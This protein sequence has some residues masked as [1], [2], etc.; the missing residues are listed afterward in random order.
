MVNTTRHTGVSVARDLEAFFDGLGRPDFVQEQ[1]LLQRI[2][3]ANEDCEYGRRYRFHE[4]KTIRDYQRNV[5]IVSYADLE[6]W[7]ARIAM[8]EPGVLTREPV[9]RFF[10]TS[11]S[12]GMSKTVPVTSSLIADKSRAFGIYWSL[13]FRSHPAAASG[14]VVGNF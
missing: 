3:R 8:G 5:P 14:K 6:P 13:L 7:I 10:A 9:R 2:V 4:I 1:C 11:G 12:T